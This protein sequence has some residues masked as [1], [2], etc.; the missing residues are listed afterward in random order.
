MARSCDMPAHARNQLRVA[1]QTLRMPSAM[2]LVMGQSRAEAKRVIARLTKQY[3][4][5][6]TKKRKR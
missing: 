4:A 2:A 1:R 6:C 3:G 5:A